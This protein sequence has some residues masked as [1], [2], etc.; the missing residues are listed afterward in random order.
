ML[1]G[2]RGRVYSVVFSPNGQQ[3]A[4]GSW[5]STVR[6]WDASTGKCLQKLEG[7]GYNVSFSPDGSNLITES[8]ILDMRQALQSDHFQWIGRGIES[9]RTWITWNGKNL[10]WLPPEYRP[11]EFTVR[12][13]CV[14]IGC[15]SGAVYI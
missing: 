9:K 13:N 15:G 1:E 5:D 14:G 7:Y 4:S 12:E 10:L 6:L 3:L 11:T 2:H 8:G